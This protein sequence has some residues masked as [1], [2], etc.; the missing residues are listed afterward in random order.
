MMIHFETDSEDGSVA[1]ESLDMPCVPREGETV[2]LRGALYGGM[3]RYTNGEGY[4][5]FKVRTVDYDIDISDGRADTTITVHLKL[6]FQD[7]QRSS[8]R[9]RCVCE[10]KN[11]EIDETEP[12]QCGNCRGLAWWTTT[13]A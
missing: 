6:H 5:I 1:L 13:K 9:P 8:F 4:T 7:E 11:R 12:T 10:V 2:T 3:R